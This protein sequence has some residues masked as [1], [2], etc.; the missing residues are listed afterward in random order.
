MRRTDRMNLLAGFLCAVLIPA[1]GTAQE[2]HYQMK[3]QRA[4]EAVVWAM[5]AVSVYDIELSIQRDLGGKFGD[6]A[7]FSE[8]MES[9]H[10]FL[11][12]NDVTPYVVSAQSTKG[13]PLVV[14]VPPAAEKVSYFGTFVDG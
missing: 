11:T 1:T 6:V 5:P 7:Y 3:V 10:G 14:E 12:A 2:V 8:P 4:A 9:R 13:G